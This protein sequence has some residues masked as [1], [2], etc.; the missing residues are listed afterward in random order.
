M[1]EKVIFIFKC[2]W[3]KKK[4]VSRKRGSFLIQGKRGG[5]WAPL[6]VYLCACLVVTLNC[7][8]VQTGHPYRRLTGLDTRFLWVVLRA[9]AKFDKYSV[10]L[11]LSWTSRWRDVY[12]DFAENCE[13]YCSLITLQCAIQTKI[14]QDL[15]SRTWTMCY[16][17]KGPPLRD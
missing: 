2:W 11:F 16:C 4:C 9:S 6:G 15:G 12:F 13:W 7:W 8:L 3:M 10:N 17:K 14:C 1:T 5:A